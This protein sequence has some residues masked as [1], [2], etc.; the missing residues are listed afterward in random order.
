MPSLKFVL[1]QVSLA[2]LHSHRMWL[3]MAMGWGWF[4]GWGL[5]P[6]PTLHDGENF[7]TSSLLLGTSQSP[8]PPYKTL[9]HV[10]LPTTIII[11]FNKTYNINK[12]ILKITNKFLSSN[13]TNFW[14]KLNNIIKM[15]NKTNHNKNKNLKMQNQ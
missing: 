7:L 9:L 12:N 10:I 6:C 13:Q 11:V 15:F 4:E 3:G 5:R 8:A 14:Q 1:F 2:I